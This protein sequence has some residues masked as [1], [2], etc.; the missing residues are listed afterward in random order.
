MKTPQSV[1]TPQFDPSRRLLLLTAPTAAAAV[2]TG[3]TRSADP[4]VGGVI[5]G[6]HGIT[7]NTSGLTPDEALAKLTEGNGRFV[8]MAEVDPN[9]SQT[10]L[11]AIAGGQQPFVAVLG[12]VDSRVPPELIFDRGLGDVF[13][14]RIAGAITDDA[15]VGS[16][17][18]GVEEFDVPLLVVLGHSKCGAVTAA[19]KAM[20]SSDAVLPGRI[21]SVVDPILPAVKTV[22]A[23]G[24]PGSEVVNATAREV[25]HR[26]VDTLSASPMFDVRI[27]DGRLRIVGAFYDLDTG[28]VDFLR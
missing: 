20:D 19:V 16:L 3:C 8:A 25:I 1:K 22:R 6:Q 24:V 26:G 18:F 23:Q 14:T 12:C 11:M 4:P 5:H 2:I 28:E 15:A 10:R 21:S 9:V 17:E 7:E 27:R 13:D